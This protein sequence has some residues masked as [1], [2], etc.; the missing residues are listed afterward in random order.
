[1]KMKASVLSFVAFE[2]LNNLVLVNL[3]P[4][5]NKV[6]CYI[7]VISSTISGGSRFSI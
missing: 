2:F 4:E 6:T 5:L 1:M 3:M 7:Y